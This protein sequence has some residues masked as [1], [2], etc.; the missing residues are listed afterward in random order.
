MSLRRVAL[1]AFCH[2]HRTSS[3]AVLKSC[4]R[5]VRGYRKQHEKQAV[6]LDKMEEFRTSSL[7]ANSASPYVEDDYSDEELQTAR[8]YRFAHPEFLPPSEPEHRDAVRELLERQDMLKRRSKLDIPEFYVGSLMAVTLS[9]AYADGFQSRFVGIC[10]ERHETGLRHNF[11]LRN[12]LDSQGIEIMYD[13]YNPT[14]K[15]I[16][17][18]KLEKRLDEHLTYLRDAPLHYS[19]VPFELEPT[20]HP[21]GAAIPINPIKV[22]LNPRPWRSRWERHD[23]KGVEGVE[24]QVKPSMLERAKEKTIAKPWEKYDLMKKYRESLPLEDQDEAYVHFV[25]ELKRI[26]AEQETERNQEE[27]GSGK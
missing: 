22:R 3:A 12:V 5:Y 17:V 20:P 4:V 19:T 9:D 21:R 18:L 7:S 25:R 23:L 15:K 26:E 10:I 2:K 24:E 8:R 14:I 13:L 16:E 27:D 11:T 6:P 1:S